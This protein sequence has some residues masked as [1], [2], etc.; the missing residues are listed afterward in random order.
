MGSVSCVGCTVCGETSNDRIGGCGIVVGSIF[1]A[2]YKV[3][4]C[5]ELAHGLVQWQALI[6]VVFRCYF[7]LIV[8]S[9]FGIAETDKLRTSS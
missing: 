6:P 5:S 3:V 1:K 9:V 4:N 7:L 2:C 8:F